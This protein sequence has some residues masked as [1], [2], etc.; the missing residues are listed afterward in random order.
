MILTVKRG[1]AFDY[2]TAALSHLLTTLF[3]MEPQE[4]WPNV[5]VITSGSDG[6]HSPNSRHYKGDAIDVR[7][8]NFARDAR[9]AFRVTGTAQT[10]K[11]VVDPNG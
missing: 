1:V 8:H 10:L 2:K 3:L 5:L 11:V 9:E 6:Q 7:S 4:G